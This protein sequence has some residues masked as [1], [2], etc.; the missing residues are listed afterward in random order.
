[1]PKKDYR[2]SSSDK[3]DLDEKKQYT[4]TLSN[5]EVIKFDLNE[6]EIETI[7]NYFSLLAKHNLRFDI[8]NILQIYDEV[9]VTQIS[10]MV[11]QSKSTVARHLQLMELDGLVTSRVS[12]KKIKGK[13][14]PKIF[15]INRKLLQIFQYS[16]INKPPPKDLNK[17]IEYYEK[18]IQEDR[19]GIYRFKQLLNLLEPLLESFEEKFGNIEKAK[20]MYEKFFNY[21]KL[22]PWFVFFY[23]NEKY[24]DDFMKL[25]KK[26]IQ[27]AL[28][29]LA[30]QNNDPEARKKSHSFIASILPV[31]ALVDIYQQRLKMKK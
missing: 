29:L 15:T 7:E 3:L 16:P 8:W 13:I 12:D 11:K 19:A 22:T 10:N 30:I 24:Y 31:K 2:L 20:R 4:I 9:N 18:A 28:K 6:K 17:L 21:T 26:F 14:P 1:L 25:Q 27:D 23:L 5:G